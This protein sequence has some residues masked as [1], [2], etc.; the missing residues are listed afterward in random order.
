[1][2][3][4]A[5]S[6]VAERGT[7]QLQTFFRIASRL[8]QFINCQLLRTYLFELAAY[9]QW[10]DAMIQEQRKSFQLFSFMFINI[11]RAERRGRGRGRGCRK[12]YRV[13]FSSS[14]R[15][16]RQPHAIRY[17]NSFKN[18]TNPTDFNM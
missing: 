3:T 17:L 8:H 14:Q 13:R 6:D 5:K 7:N 16:I 2:L 1:M 15:K 4:I 12:H 18:E 10:P 11:T 9:Q